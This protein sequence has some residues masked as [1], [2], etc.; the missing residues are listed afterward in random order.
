MI[1]VA[2]RCGRLSDLATLKPIRT[3]KVSVS[4]FSIELSTAWPLPAVSLFFHMSI[5]SAP[6][7]L[8]N[9]KSTTL[10]AS[11]RTYLAT[12]TERE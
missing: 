9:W 4:S 6:N 12:K 5:V 1:H 7:Q 10:K 3:A 8:G 2:M 11:A